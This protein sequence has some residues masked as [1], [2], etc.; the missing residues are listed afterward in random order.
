MNEGERPLLQEIPQELA[1]NLA[2]Y[3]TARAVARFAYYRLHPDE[4]YLFPKYYKPG[5]NI[6]DLACGM[7]RTT[8][9][10]YEMG[11]K[12]RGVDRS[13]VFIEIAKRRLPYLDLQVGSY[14]QINEP[15]SSFCH[16]LISHNGIDYAFP[17]EQRLTAL[18]ECARVLRPGGTFIYSSHNLKSLHW[19]SPY[20]RDRLRW[21]LCNCSKA[22]KEWDYV[23]EDGVNTL[24][25]SSDFVIRQTEAVGLKL[26]EAKCFSK[27]KVDRIDKYFSPYISYVFM[28]PND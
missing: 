16:V 22:F 3:R 13:D 24:Y 12:V 17:A 9:L 23:L 5:D 4:E 7:G 8:L 2:A 19:F 6:L 1:E 18:L 21:K 27:F 10:L 26:L 25:A 20:Y 28:K 14:D 11:L 15:D